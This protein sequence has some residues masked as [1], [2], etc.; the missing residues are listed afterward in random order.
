MELAALYHQRWEIEAV[1]DELKT[2][3]RQSRRVLRSKTPELVRQEFYGWVLAHYAVRWLLHQGASSTEYR[4]PSCPSRGMWSCFDAHSPAPGP[5]PPAR[6]KRRRRWFREL[7]QASGCIRATRT[8][9]RRSPRMVKRRNSPYAGHDRDRS[10]ARSRR[11]SRPA[12]S[13]GH[14][15]HLCKSPAITSVAMVTN[16]SRGRIC[17]LNEQYWLMVYRP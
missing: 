8:L 7:L 6:P 9:N 15:V 5:F 11:T 3:L 13:L 10:D 1:F 2:H 4:T 14:Q 12:G 17:T 16:K